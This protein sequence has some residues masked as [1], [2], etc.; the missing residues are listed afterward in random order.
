MTRNSPTRRSFLSSLSAAPALLRAAQAQPTRRPNI[1]FVF[2]DDHAYQAISAYGSAVNRTPNI[3]RIAREGMRFDSALVTNSI[4]GPSRAVILTGKYSHLNGFKDN[5]S[6]FD[7]SQQTFPKLLGAAGYQ[8]AIFGKWHLV[9]NPTGF[10]AWQVLPGQGSYYN[11]DF[12]TPSGRKR[13]DGY[14]TEITTDLSLDWLN[15][16]DKSKPWLL[17]CQHKAPH[18]NWLPA[19]SKL[20]SYEG[21]KFPEP[22]TLFDDYEHR[23]TPARKQTMEIGRHMTLGSDLK[24]V[25]G[26]PDLQ[27]PAGEFKRMNEAQRRMWDAA[28]ARRNREFRE[29]KLEGKELLRWKY[30]Q[31]M[32]DYLGC[33]DSVDDSVGRLLNWLDANGEAEN[34]IVVYASDQGFY[35]GEHGWFDKRWIYEQ[36]IRTPMLARWPGVA[37]PGSTSSQMVSNIDLPETFLEAAGAPVPADMQGRSMSSILRGESPRD[38]RK[39]FYYHYYEKGVHDVAPHDGVRTDRYTFAHYYESNEWELFDRQKDPQQMRSVFADPAYAAAVKELK[40]ELT[41]LRKELKVE[42]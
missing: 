12:I 35:L 25:A 41:R 20:Q 17:M 18:R 6:T 28:Y 7:G 10:D 31:Y 36:S 19:P 4:C 23:A 40:T 9:S 16:R 22:P 26:G 2:S 27:G 37:K 42:A 39:T 32:Q 21:V 15:N 34:T 3:D 29:R 8:T 13:Y 38:W 1:L 33:I 14:V 11:P 24:V 30:Q 5:A